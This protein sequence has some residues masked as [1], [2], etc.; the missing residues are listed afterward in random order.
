MKTKEVI[1]YFGSVRIAARELDLSTA[2]I[3]AWGEYPP[4]A[5]Q[6]QIELFTNGELKADKPEPDYIRRK[7]IRKENVE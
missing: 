2:A 3:Y 6:Y 1:D 4:I 5:R 7:M